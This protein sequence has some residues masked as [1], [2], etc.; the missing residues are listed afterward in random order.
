[1]GHTTTNLLALVV[2][3]M[4]V[5]FSYT[6]A[7]FQYAPARQLKAQTRVRKMVKNTIFVLREQIRNTKQTSPAPKR[8][9]LLSPMLVLQHTAD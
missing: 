3:A 8:Q 5:G 9:L 4:F 1:M 7:R 2:A 6:S